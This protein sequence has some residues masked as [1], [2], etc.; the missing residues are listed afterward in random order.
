MAR[1]KRFSTSN[2]TATATLPAA[3]PSAKTSQ[4]ESFWTTLTKS[5][6]KN[7]RMKP[8]E[9]TFVLRSLTTLV[10]N[11]VSLPKALS[12]LAKEDS[13]AKHRDVLNGL[14]RKLESGVPFSKA[15][16][17]VPHVCDQLT[18]NQIRVGERS[19][20]LVDTL[21]QL[22]TT[23][24][25]SAELRQQVIKKMAYP[26]ILVT[27]GTGLIIFLLLYVVPVF[28]ET[29][30]KANIP[31]PL[32]TRALIQTGALV[33]Q[34]GPMLLL[35]V[36]PTVLTIKQLRKRTAFAQKMDRTLLRVPLVGPWLRDMA[37]LQLMEVLNNLMAAGYT[38][39]EALGQAADSVR[40]RAVRQGVRG[41]QLAVQ[42]GERFS[43]ELER[44]EDMFP[45][46]VNQLVI[47]GESTGQ[48]GRA[49][50]DICT[51]LRREIERKTTLLV[52]SL[53]PI[54]TIGLAGSI[55]VVLLA[56]YLPM[57]DMIN[58]V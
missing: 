9:L 37:V 46:I 15:L 27:V 8:K 35:V 13:L 2:G 21:K 45:P 18:V 55:A 51:F 42:R 28:Q 31:L 53:E 17:A 22:A 30:D 19:G 1:R 39:A 5:R 26:G 40:N 32:V 16:E 23:R 48:L 58:A 34:F 12:T 4:N 14:C 56:I 38:L 6:S 7:E 50:N 52:G 33:K 10:D 41:L 43:R 57:F 3:N 44:Q 36:I 20:T 29:Y 54:L 11:G 24:D 49:T 47:V 25:Q